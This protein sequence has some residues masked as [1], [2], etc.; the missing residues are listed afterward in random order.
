[1]TKI[2]VL[3]DNRPSLSSPE[4]LSEHG[5]SLW[6]EHSGRTILVDTGASDCFLRNANRMGIDLSKAECVV[7]S[8]SHLDHTGG[9]SALIG[10]GYRRP[11]Y[12]A[13]HFFYPRFSSRHAGL[14]HDLSAPRAPFAELG[15]SVMVVEGGIRFENFALV[16]THEF[17]YPLPAAN[18]SLTEVFDGMERAD[19][20][21]HEQSLCLS[22]ERGLVI[23]SP[24]SHCGVGNIIRSCKTSLG[25]KRVAAFVGGFH[26]P[27]AEGVEREAAE[28]ADIILTEAPEA[29]VFTGHCTGERAAATL[30]ERLPRFSLFHTGQIIE[31]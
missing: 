30:S 9:V 10:S 29:H 4:L 3:V 22:T 31:I 7:F 13:P 2:T 21:V 28:L 27:D 16:P 23:I 11:I 5:L 18:R 8:H 17:T 1:M 26:L 19:R 6:V 24:C 25:D 12:L 14:R 20:F 15:D